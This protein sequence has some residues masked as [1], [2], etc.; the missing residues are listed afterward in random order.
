MMRLLTLCECFYKTPQLRNCCSSPDGSVD[1]RTLVQTNLG[2]VTGGQASPGQSSAPGADHGGQRLSLGRPAGET[3][4]GSFSDS[5]GKAGP[6]RRKLGGH[7]GNETCRF[8]LKREKRE[9]EES[10]IPKRSRLETV[11]TVAV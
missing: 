2:S 4:R 10:S 5:T 7:T 8:V 1:G 3:E 6:T 9:G 11:R